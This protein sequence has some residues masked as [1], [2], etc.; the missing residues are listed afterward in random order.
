MVQTLLTKWKVLDIA[1]IKGSRIIYIENKLRV[2]TI[3]LQSWVIIVLRWDQLDQVVGLA[4]FEEERFNTTIASG[5]VD[6]PFYR[7]GF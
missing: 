4:T 7:I 2:F 1:N 6:N 5:N 3:S